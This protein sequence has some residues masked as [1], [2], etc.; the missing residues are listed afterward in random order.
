MLHLFLFLG[1]ALAGP[2]PDTT[3]APLPDGTEVVVLGLEDPTVIAGPSL[4]EVSFPHPGFPEEDILRRL[5]KLALSRGANLVKVTADFHRT[6]YSQGLVG[7]R[8]YK[9]AD[10]RAYEP[11]I[12]WSADRRLTFADFTALPLSPDPGHSECIFYLPA[13]GYVPSLEVPAT[14]ARFLTRSSWIDSPAGNPNEL[15]LHEQGA[16]DL[17]ELYRRKLD[18]VIYSF[19]RSF[20]S[21]PLLQSICNQVYA[22]YLHTRDIYDSATHNGLDSAQQCLWTRRIAAGDLPLAPM[23]TRR[24]LGQQAQDLQPATHRALVYVIRPN[25][26]NTPFWKRMALEPYY[27]LAGAYLLVLN[28][29]SYS[30]AFDGVNQGSIGVRKFVY[31]YMRPGTYVFYSPYGDS[32]LTLRLDPGKIY[33]IKM[34]LINRRFFGGDRPEWE[35]LSEERGRRWL[36]KCRLSRHW[37]YFNLPVFPDPLR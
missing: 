13:G 21:E 17:C 19:P 2:L 3:I 32:T 23:L 29:R 37:E 27:L 35:L 4:G 16:F 24:Q 1:M 36:R 31:R 12:D 15:L 14:R 26:Y 34:K 9:V 30:V 5:R 18:S 6:R 11:W 20:S 10:V 8:I 25:Q 22:G 28:P 7:A 33:Y